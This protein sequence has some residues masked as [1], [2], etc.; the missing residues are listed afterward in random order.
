[1][2]LAPFTEQVQLPD[3]QAAVGVF[4]TSDVKGGRSRGLSLTSL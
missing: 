4:C 2:S 3:H 1:M